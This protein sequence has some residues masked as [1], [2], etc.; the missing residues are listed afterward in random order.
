[1]WLEEGYGGRVRAKWGG[2]GKLHRGRGSTLLIKSVGALRNVG[3]P[4]PDQLAC[5]MVGVGLPDK[6][7]CF[8][9][10]PKG[11]LTVAGVDPLG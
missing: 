2:G 11:V 6:C 9:K 3:N 8:F 1:M 5:N 7:Q 10:V 4:T